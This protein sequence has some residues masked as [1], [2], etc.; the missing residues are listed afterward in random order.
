MT[1]EPKNSATI[2]DPNEAWMT[3]GFL[4]KVLGGISLTSIG[5]SLRMLN[6]W[7]RVCLGEA[8]LP[9]MGRGTSRRYSV[10]DATCLGIGLRLVNE[11]H[12]AP[13]QTF[14]CVATL[15]TYWNELFPGGYQA[16]YANY[17]QPAKWKPKFLIAS[18]WIPGQFE[19]VIVDLT[20]IIPKITGGQP[21][22]ICDVATGIISST[23]YL[24]NWMNSPEQLRKWAGL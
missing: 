17:P 22:V 9:A 7:T 1:V 24:L 11:L 16:F 20:E 14:Y 23:T 10:V 15:K 13:A 21:L 18:G 8:A 12:L 6:H 5:M 4:L 3:P 2:P 19:V